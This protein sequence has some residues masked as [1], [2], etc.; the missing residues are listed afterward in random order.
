MSASVE[1]LAASAPTHFPDAL[2]YF[3]NLLFTFAVS[4]STSSKNSKRTSPPPDELPNEDLV[5]VRL[6]LS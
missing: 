4:L 1:P 2:S 5:I 3:K 6:I